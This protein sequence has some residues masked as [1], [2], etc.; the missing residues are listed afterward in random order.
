MF[1]AA[2][3]L[4]AD[5]GLATAVF[6]NSDRETDERALNQLLFALPRIVPDERR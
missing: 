6:A 1:Y 5:R 2:V 4:E 3:V